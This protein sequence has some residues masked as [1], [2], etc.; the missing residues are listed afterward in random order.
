VAA[1]A[2]AAATGVAIDRTVLEPSS[3]RSSQTAAELDPADG[4]WTP[5]ATQAELAPGTARRFDTPGV[6][7]FVSGAQT[8][9]VAVSAACTHLGCILEQNAQSGR[10]DCPCHRTAFGYDGKLLFSQLETTPRC[11]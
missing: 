5:V 9:V 6:V 3:G 7:G 1:G 4:Q 11:R 10:L 8:G 2:A